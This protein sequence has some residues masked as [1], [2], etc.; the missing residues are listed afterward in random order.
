MLAGSGHI[1]GVVNPPSRPKYQYWTNDKPLAP[2]FDKWLKAAT[3]H[4]GSWWPDW[5]EWL[6]AARQE[7]RAGAQSRQQDVQ[8]DRGRAGILCQNEELKRGVSNEG[9]DDQRIAVAHAHHHSH[10]RLVGALHPRSHPGARPDGH[11]GQSVA[12]RQAAVALGGAAL[13][14]AHQRGRQSRH[15]RAAG[16]DARR[17]RPLDA[18]H[19]VGLRGLFL[20]AARAR[21]RL[22][23]RH[24][25]AAHWLASDS[26]PG[27]AG[28]G[29][30]G[31]SDAGRA[32][33]PGGIRA[34]SRETAR[35][36]RAPSSRGSRASDSRSGS[37]D[38]TRPSPD[39]RAP[40]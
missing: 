20:R 33:P 5:L 13:F 2:D 4:A 23:A 15:L 7:A 39:C 19:G 1:A 38:P 8:A 24:S 3:E 16:S 12:A 10:R 26:S 40:R 31:W 36:A 11:D 27:R 34:R 29:D 6:K 28:A 30:F 17:A 22:R 32:G 35:P 18:R 25:G 14:R 21:D 37:P 9:I